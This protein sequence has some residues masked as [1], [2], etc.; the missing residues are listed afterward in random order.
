MKKKKNNSTTG[1]LVLVFLAGLSLM[2][3][4]AVSNFVN[5]HSQA[6]VIAT[7]REELDT[8]DAESHARMIS[9]ANTYNKALI[10]REN[11][12]SLTPELQ[13]Q[14]EALLDVSGSGVMGYVDIPCIDC[15]LPVYHGT[16]EDVL[17]QAAGH[18]EWSSLPVGG[19][20]THCVI[21]GH[22]GLPT[23]ELMTHIDRLRLGDRFYLHVLDQ[24]L[25]YQVDQIKVV[26]PEDASYLTIEEGKD[27]V[28]LVTCTP[29]GINSH[30]LLVRGTRVLNG[31]VSGGALILNNEV[32]AVS[33]VYILPVAL[34][35]LVF[36]TFCALGLGRLLGK[37]RKK[38]G[39][40]HEEEPV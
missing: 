29:Y 36:V 33:L 35:L 37:K 40:V 24:T 11:E 12:F 15:T 9:Q 10:E 34:L 6:R 1:L 18:V 13:Q 27:L 8:L 26:L 19:E 23:A 4:P 31:K 21:S 39:S 28:T 25:E 17:Q 2:L 14:Y 38:E 3:Y 32:E 22:R 5:S 7:Y 20:S 16:K 30:R